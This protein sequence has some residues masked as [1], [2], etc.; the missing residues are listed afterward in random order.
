MTYREIQVE[1]EKE[2]NTAINNFNL[3]KD[4]N[5]IFAIERI[6]QNYNE[7]RKIYD[8]LVKCENCEWYNIEIY[9]QLTK[10]SEITEIKPIRFERYKKLSNIYKVS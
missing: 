8:F 6:L 9:I 4:N 3:F 5:I 10:L 7:R 1:L 2:I